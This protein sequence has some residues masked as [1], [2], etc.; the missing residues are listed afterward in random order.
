KGD[1]LGDGGGI[2]IQSPG[3]VSA[4]NTILA[5]NTDQG[6]GSIL[7][8]C[9]GLISSLGYNL[10]G[11]PTG[12]TILGT[13][14]GNLLFADP[15][16]G[17]LQNN[18]GPTFTRMPQQAIMSCSFTYPYTCTVKQKPSPAVDA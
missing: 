2:A 11:D 18:G 14:T 3:N 16:L 1:G 6:P 15:L 9:F 13:T 10:F 4:A 7:P 8:D 5:K 12:C 17:P